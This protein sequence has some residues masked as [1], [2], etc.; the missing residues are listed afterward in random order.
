MTR[1][2]EKPAL[3]GPVGAAPN[4]PAPRVPMAPVP[5]PAAADPW[6]SVGYPGLADTV[7]RICTLCGWTHLST[8]FGRTMAIVAPSEGDG[9]SSLARAMAVTMALDH[10]CEVLLVE[11]NVLR[12]TLAEDLKI[13]SDPGLM[14]ILSGR[15]DFEDGVHETPIPNLAVMPAGS[16]HEGPS[17]LLRS[18]AMRGMLEQ[19]KRQFLFIV[20][21]LPAIMATSDSAVLAR[22]ADG[23]TL[24]VRNG[25]TTEQV[26]HQ[27]QQYLTGATVHGVVLNRWQTHVPAVLRRIVER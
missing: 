5:A 14:D 23:V 12:P 17:R 13:H 9:A 19:A 25:V 11:C 3:L 2:S 26:L 1:K 27:A 20:L 16:V 7:R 8:A 18:A 21:E 24:V 15:I 10:D 4:P 22:L 6:Q